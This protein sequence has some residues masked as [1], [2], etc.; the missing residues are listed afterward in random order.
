MSNEIQLGCV[1]THG[2]KR[3]E[4]HVRQHI[5]TSALNGS[6]RTSLR[7]SLPSRCAPHIPYHIRESTRITSQPAGSPLP[8]HLLVIQA[9]ALGDH[10]VGQLHL[11]AR[12][13]AL[14]RLQGR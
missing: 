7:T 4:S 10:S 3:G 12:L 5:T 8:A 6:M 1:M 14:W 2:A 13:E 11:H 9:G